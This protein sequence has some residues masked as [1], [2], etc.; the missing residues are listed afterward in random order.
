MTTTWTLS[1][2]TGPITPNP[3]IPGSQL[4]LNYY[5]ET[6]GL[7]ATQPVTQCDCT[8]DDDPVSVVLTKAGD[9]WLDASKTSVTRS[10]VSA[11]DAT[12][13]GN[14]TGTAVTLSFPNPTT[15]AGTTWVYDMIS[16]DRVAGQEPIALKVKIVVKRPPS[17]GR[18]S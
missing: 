17:E 7:S 15:N 18:P 4:D 11:P 8:G 10:P 1:N 3:V 6:V 13:T 12:W 9:N 5:N 2:S 16:T 14:S